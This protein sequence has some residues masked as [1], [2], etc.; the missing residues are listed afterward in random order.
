MRARAYVLVS[1]LALANGAWN[2]RD[3]SAHAN[4][5]FFKGQALGHNNVRGNKLETEISKGSL[6]AVEGDGSTARPG[7]AVHVKKSQ[8]S[9]KFAPAE[10][11]KNNG[12]N[13]NRTMAEDLAAVAALKGAFTPGPVVNVATLPGEENMAEALMPSQVLESPANEEEI[14]SQAGSGESEASTAWT[15]SNSIKS[16]LTAGLMA[17]SGLMI[18]SGAYD[19]LPTSGF[20][21]RWR[22]QWMI[23]SCFLFLILLFLGGHEPL[24]MGWIWYLVTS[25][26][27][28]VLVGL[29][30]MTLAYIA[31]ITEYGGNYSTTH[32]P[33]FLKIKHV[34]LAAAFII[35][36]LISMSLVL[37][38]DEKAFDSIRHFTSFFY[39]II[40]GRELWKAL[41]GILH[42]ENYLATKQSQSKF[43]I[44]GKIEE[45]KDSYFDE[46]KHGFSHTEDSED[47]GTATEA[48]HGYS[49]EDEDVDERSHTDLR[50]E[51]SHD[52]GDMRRDRHH[53]QQQYH[54]GEYEDVDVSEYDDGDQADD[55]RAHTAPS[56]GER[57]VVE[58]RPEES[59]VFSE[60]EHDVPYDTHNNGHYEDEVK[61]TDEYQ[62]VSEEDEV[63]PEGYETN[64]ET[65]APTQGEP[66][67]IEFVNEGSRWDHDDV[68]EDG[69]TQTGAQ[70]NH[71]GHHYD[72]EEGDSR[73]ESDFTGSKGYT[74]SDTDDGM[75]SRLSFNET[76]LSYNS[77]DKKSQSANGMGVD[78]KTRQTLTEDTKSYSKR[79]GTRTTRSGI[80][81]ERTKSGRTMAESGAAKARVRRTIYAVVVMWIIA[82]WWTFFGIYQSFKFDP[83]FSVSTD[84]QADTYRLSVDLMYW[85][86]LAGVAYMQHWTRIPLC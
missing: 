71:Q 11:K 33:M 12:R 82:Q 69:Y 32:V 51:F 49:D 84:E 10:H 61:H 45:E 1:L 55:D 30:T 83:R 80:G 42:S 25:T 85:S 14:L 76:G 22:M 73:R 4:A 26:A 43:I 72:D 38:T 68:D 41:R 3:P 15:I 46:K 35:L 5:K 36:N 34:T 19:P 56:G 75:V 52:E 74:D 16:A 81:S 53:Q 40:Y 64:H 23:V 13:I 37:A 48:K 67:R 62:S 54:D 29:I 57:R 31:V 21:I 79:G 6:G 27:V 58:T 8:W 59:A 7:H 44:P 86:T 63:H 66:M 70:T 24:Y 65:N 18:I 9:K 28:T 60:S 50:D 78:S 47:Y 17:Y 2:H 77:P 39:V 20:L